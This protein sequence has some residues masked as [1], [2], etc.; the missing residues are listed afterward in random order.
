M[1]KDSNFTLGDIM[2]SKFWATY[3]SRITSRRFPYPGRKTWV[4][5]GGLGRIVNY[6]VSEDWV[7]SGDGRRYL[8]CSVVEMILGYLEWDT[9]NITIPRERDGHRM[10]LRL[11]KDR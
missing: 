3:A 5:Y 8:S 9:V 11:F 1:G 2:S 10:T 7:I 4:D 6:A